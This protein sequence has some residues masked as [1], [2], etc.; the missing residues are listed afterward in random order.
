MGSLVP[1]KRNNAAE[2]SA[3]LAMAYFHPWTLRGNEEEGD[4]V[5]YA[6]SLRTGEDAWEKALRKMLDG[7]SISQG[8]LRYVGY[9]LSVYRVRPRDPNEDARSDEYF[10]DEK[11]VIDENMLERAMQSRV[12][13][14]EQDNVNE[15]KELITGQNES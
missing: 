2:T 9:L 7:N 8:S 10:D 4:V 13:G 6:G 5:P 1:S 11:L 14:K 15:M 12:G 3:M